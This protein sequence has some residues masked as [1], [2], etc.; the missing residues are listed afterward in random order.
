MVKIEKHLPEFS[1]KSIF[2]KPVNINS[3]SGENWD[4]FSILP[5]SVLTP[6]SNFISTILRRK[7]LF[8][9]LKRFL[10]KTHIPIFMPR[11]SMPVR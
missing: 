3:K 1:S 9:R 7:G 2:I 11:T 8:Y 6:E 10:I 4:Y 5:V